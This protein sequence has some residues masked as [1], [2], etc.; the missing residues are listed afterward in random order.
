MIPFV[1]FGVGGVQLDFTPQCCVCFSICE[2]GKQWIIISGDCFPA[3]LPQ[4]C[5]YCSY[6]HQPC[7]EA[8]TV[9]TSASRISSLLRPGFNCRPDFTRG[10]KLG[11]TSSQ[12]RWEE[13]GRKRGLLAGVCQGS[14]SNRTAVIVCV[15][16]RT[17]ACRG[18][19]VVR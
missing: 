6:Q 18:I 11:A 10:T 7:A 3:P 1:T 12:C 9:N 8:E 16:V 17:G 14:F 19:S 13:S 5:R 2:Q 15:V 4:V